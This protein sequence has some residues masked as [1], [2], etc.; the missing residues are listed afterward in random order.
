[1]S[2]ASSARAYATIAASIRRRVSRGGGGG[3]AGG[4]A[5][6]AAGAGFCAAGGV[7]GGATVGVMSRGGARTTAL[8]LA[9]VA[10]C[11]GAGQ[12]LRRCTRGR[13]PARGLRTL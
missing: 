1:M 11:G 6:T 7:T 9:I 8:V 3:G 4:T 13:Y 12:G 10:R 5:S 2:C